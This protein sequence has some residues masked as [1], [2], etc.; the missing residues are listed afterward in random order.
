MMTYLGL[1]ALEHEAPYKPSLCSENKRRLAAQI[2]ASDKVGMAF[3]GRPPLIS[4]QYCSTALP[5][6]IRDEDLTGGVANIARAAE[7]LNG[8]GWNT[9]GELYPATF[10]R[11]RS[12]IAF[13]R[14]EL[15]EV[16]LSKNVFVTIDHLQ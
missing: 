14:D 5:L 8:Q 6:D 15:L 16:S 2:F 7:S 13:V 12:M 3:T 1:H 4:R 10:I 9:K 11:A